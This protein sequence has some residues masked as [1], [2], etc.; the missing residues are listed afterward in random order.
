MK[1]ATKIWLIAALVFLTGGIVLTAVSASSLNYNFS[2]TFSSQ[3]EE[4]SFQSSD[5]IT[6][7]DINGVSADITLKP[8][9]NHDVLVEY[10]QSKQNPYVVELKDGTLSIHMDSSAPWY[11]HI[12]FMDMVHAKFDIYLPE[13]EYEA[14][15]LHTVSGNI[16]AAEKAMT[17][18]GNLEALTVSGEI[19]VRNVTA[20]QASVKT[21][22]GDITLQDLDVSSLSCQSISGEIEMKN[23]QSKGDMTVESTS[24]DL[25]LTNC[26]TDATLT[27][28]TVSGDVTENNT[29]AKT[30]EFHSVSGDHIL[31]SSVTLHP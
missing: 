2:E 1:L 29:S 30:R 18:K 22:S 27:L 15:T 31:T 3:A 20:D 14:V 17:V 23:C 21:T 26:R 25:V 12:H 28:H 16:T 13:A 8:S 24:G 10:V 6:K 7:L 11:S 19:S 4:K 9:A 5:P